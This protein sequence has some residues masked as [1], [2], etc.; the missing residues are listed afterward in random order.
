MPKVAT[1][2]GLSKKQ[3]AFVAETLNPNI[4]ITQAAINA[5]YSPKTAYSIGSENLK[6]PEITNAI[7]AV[8][9]S[10][11]KPKVKKAIN[12]YDEFAEQLEFAKKT[13]LAAEKWLSN[14]NNPDEFLI[15]PRADEIDIVYLDFEDRTKDGDP[16]RK[17]LSLQEILARLEGTRY[18]TSAQFIKTV[19]LR[20]WALKA[21]DRCD[22]AIDKFARLGGD[23]T[24]EKENSITSLDQAKALIESTLEANPEMTLEDIVNTNKFKMTFPDVPMSELV[25]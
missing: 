13:R 6:K 20:D 7:N 2:N 9:E 18:E 5:G 16:K 10:R 15:N 11:V 19:D 1:V 4:S 3:Q 17:T 8:V 25:Q 12:T 23:Y 21:I 24:K 14:P 22:T